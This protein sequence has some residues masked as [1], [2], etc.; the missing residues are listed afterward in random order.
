MKQ[1]SGGVE[2]RTNK[3]IIKYSICRIRQRYPLSHF[4]ANKRLAGMKRFPPKYG[5][6]S[7]DTESRYHWLKVL[8]TYY[9]KDINAD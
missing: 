5:T 4:A 1:Q 8:S 7:C 9:R 2:V 6:F 3:G